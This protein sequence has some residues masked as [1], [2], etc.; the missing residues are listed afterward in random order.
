[1]ADAK[2]SMEL[3]VSTN[4]A[5]KK[6]KEFVDSTSEYMADAYDTTIA[7]TQIQ[8]LRTSVG[9][10]INEVNALPRAVRNMMSSTVASMVN[11]V[12]SIQDIINKGG[13]YK[14]PAA[15][16]VRMNQSIGLASADLEDLQKGLRLIREITSAGVDMAKSFDQISGIGAVAKDLTKRMAA[17]GRGADADTSLRRYLQSNPEYKAAMGTLG[18][19]ATKGVS[20]KLTDFYISQAINKAMRKD[21]LD[22]AAKKSGGTIR[23]DEGYVYKTLQDRLPGAFKGMKFDI[24]GKTSDRRTNTFRVSRDLTN[25]LAKEAETNNILRT[26]IL[27]AGAG[28]M[29]NGNLRTYTQFRKDQL[30]EIAGYVQ[31]QLGLG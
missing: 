14:D 26:A 23:P 30:N 24:T 21:Y 6:V 8:Q 10:M 13:H 29:D 9:A 4:L 1:M 28:Y 5:N 20:D 2:V 3:E 18:S 27:R 12:T 19:S 22:T 17:A 16:N 25:R 31:Y 7:N 15:A 11:S